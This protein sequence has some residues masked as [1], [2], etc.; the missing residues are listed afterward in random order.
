M[1]II[2]RCSKGEQLLLRIT[3]HIAMYQQY[4][5]KCSTHYFH[6]NVISLHMTDHLDRIRMPT[7]YQGLRVNER[8]SFPLSSLSKGDNSKDS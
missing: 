5:S 8:T 2:Q 6:F 3:H 7:N 4:I 1:E